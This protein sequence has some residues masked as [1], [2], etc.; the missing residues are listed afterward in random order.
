MNQELKENNY[1]VIEK[2]IAKKES[3]RLADSFKK[4][5]VENNLIGDPQIPKSKS[6]YNYKEFFELLC[7]KTSEVSKLLGENVFPTYA[8]SRVYGRGDI[9]KRHS[10]REACE[11]SITLNLSQKTPWPIF[12]QKPDGTESSVT[13]QP[14]NAAL[15]LGYDAE[16]WR[17]PYEGDELV[18]VFLHYV[19]SN[20]EK[21]GFAFD[22]KIGS[23]KFSHPESTALESAG[24]EK[25]IVYMENVVPLDLCDAILKEYKDSDE[26]EQSRIG[27]GPNGGEENPKIR[28]AKVIPISRDHILEKNPDVRKDLDKRLFQCAGEAISK[29]AAQF[30]ECYIALDTGYELL[31]YKEGEGY[32]R[33]T[34]DFTSEP[35]VISCSFCLNDEYT[36]GEFNMLD[37][38]LSFKQKKG[39][40]LLFPSNFMY[41]HEV[42]KVVS[43]TRY[44]IV[45]W[46]R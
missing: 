8:Y 10:D 15:Y 44:S 36:G 33:H 3:K 34:D 5:A 42:A 37:Q 2:F 30:P 14:G 29:Y 26:W 12:F 27:G 38:K 24:L 35:R 20:G 18:Q 16:H 46:F 7:N 41:P 43:G 11:I 31:R 25:Y 4:F 23:F 13:L 22:N 9:L 28:G 32:A 45:T 6:C 21:A 39:S 1:V 19:R 17:E 40:V